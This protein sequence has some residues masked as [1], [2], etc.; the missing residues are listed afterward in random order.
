MKVELWPISCGVEQQKV[1]GQFLNFIWKLFQTLQGWS[2]LMCIVTVGKKF[3]LIKGI[4]DSS[5]EKKSSWC[6]PASQ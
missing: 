1:K 2:N 3:K 4:V 5:E 6:A